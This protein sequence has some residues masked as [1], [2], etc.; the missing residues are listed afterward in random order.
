MT[1]TLVACSHG[2]ADAEGSAAVTALVDLVLD[3]YDA[4]RPVPTP[5]RPARPGLRA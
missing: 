4:V 1:A 5:C 2:T 3:R